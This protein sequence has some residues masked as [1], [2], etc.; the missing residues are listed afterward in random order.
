[1]RAV[2]PLG[3]I[4][5][6]VVAGVLCALAVGLKYKFGYDDSLDVVGVHLVGGVVGSLLIGFLATGDVTGRRRGPVLRRRLRPARQAGRRRRRGL[7]YSFV[8]RRSSSAF[9]IDKTIGFRVDEDDEVAGI[10]L[11]EHAETGYDFS[12]CGGGGVSPR[13]AAR[14]RRPHRERADEKVDA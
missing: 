4:V 12:R 13:S 2:D 14:R 1:M 11:A 9:V 6:G 10:D 3:A 7:A 8:R 5:V